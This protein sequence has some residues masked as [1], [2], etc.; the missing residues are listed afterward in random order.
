MYVINF[1][2]LYH[3]LHYYN[4][5]YII[6]YIN[7]YFNSNNWNFME[8]QNYKHNHIWGMGLRIFDTMLRIAL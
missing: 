3:L 7:Y 4:F 2:Y 1:T 6:Y 8:K 5:T